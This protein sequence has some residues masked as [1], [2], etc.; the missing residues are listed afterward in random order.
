MSDLARFLHGVVTDGSAQLQAPPLD[1]DDADARVVL[2]RAYDVYALSLAGPALPL[3]EEIALAAAHLLERASWYLL[4]SNL[5]IDDARRLAM[6]APPRTPEQHLSADLVLR[7]LPALYRR[8]AA[9]LPGDVL[10][11]VLE[12][13]LRDWPLSGVL[14]DILEPPLTPVDFGNHAGLNFLYAERLAEHDRPDW[15]PLGRG[16]EYVELVRA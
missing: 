3:D 8:A 5:P 6:P 12:K 9:M 13:A 14:A 10:P 1:G 15:H 16:A 11:Q 4:N 2:R 7:Y